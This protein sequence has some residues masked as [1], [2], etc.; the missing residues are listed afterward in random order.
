MKWRGAGAWSVE[1]SYGTLLSLEKCVSNGWK[2]ALS[3]VSKK[4]FSIPEVEQLGVAK[5]SSQLLN[6]FKH[7]R[8]LVANRCTGFWPMTRTRS[9]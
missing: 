3:P 2:N 6:H 8:F 4:I 5:W 1:L 7:A 9:A